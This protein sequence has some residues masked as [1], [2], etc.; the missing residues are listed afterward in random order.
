VGAF[1]SR[2]S[3]LLWLFRWAALPLLEQGMCCL[4]IRSV[5]APGE[6]TIDLRQELSSGLRPPLTLPQPAQAHG[7]AYL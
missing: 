2:Y 4:K 1:E 5:E 7:G 6:P 3:A